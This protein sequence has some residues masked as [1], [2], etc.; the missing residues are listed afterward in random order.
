MQHDTAGDPITGVKWSRR[1]TS[2]IAEQRTSLGI[3]VSKNTVGRLLK[4]LNYKLRVNRKQIASTNSPDRSRQ[5]LYIGQQRERFASQGQPIIR[6]ETKKKELIGNFKN[7]GAKWDRK[8]V[9]VN[10]HDFR[11]D[12]GGL[13]IP[14][15]I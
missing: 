15:G 13:A 9:L 8:P 7:T 10:D 3:A 6:V 14:Y 1:T 2:K 5:F 11:S 4:Q 12:A